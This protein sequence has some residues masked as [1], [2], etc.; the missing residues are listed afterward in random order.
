MIK[1]NGSYELEERPQM[2]GGPG[3]VT[4]EKYFK[5]EEFGGEHVRV[6]SKLILPPGS[7]IG[8]HAHNGEDEVY[9]VL[10]GKGRVNDNGNIS[11]ISVGDTVLTGRGESHSV[12]CIGTET[13]EI[14]ALVVTY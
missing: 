6:C 14:L 7:G 1:R 8:L 2:K 11:D 12:E 10:K 13:L 3:T 5:K 4:M 9:I